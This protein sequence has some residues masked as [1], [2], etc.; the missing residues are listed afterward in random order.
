VG[1]LFEEQKVLVPLVISDDI[2][3]AEIGYPMA[4]VILDGLVTSTLLNLFVVRALYVR[5]GRSGTGTT[6]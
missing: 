6:A 5:L 4:L 1:S 2:P 3:G